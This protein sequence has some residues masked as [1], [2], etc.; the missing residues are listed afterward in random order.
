MGARL[1]APRPCGLQTPPAH[2]PPPSQAII[3]RVRLNNEPP[4]PADKVLGFESRADA[5]AYLQAHS[6]STLGAVH[7][8]EAANG[9][10]QFLLQSSSIVSRCCRRACT[11]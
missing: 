5:E 9:D 2:L 10:L 11:S 7:F 8:S 6:G 1:P 4:I 3:E